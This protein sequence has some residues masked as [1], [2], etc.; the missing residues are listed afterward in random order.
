MTPCLYVK[1]Q[2]VKFDRIAPAG[3]KILAVLQ[4][5]T[6]VF[7]RDLVITCATEG[8]PAS[9]AHAL[10]EAYDVR[11]A[12]LPEATVLSLHKYLSTNL[13]PRF[14]VLYEVPAKPA[15]VLGGIA[16]VNPKATAAHFH[17]QRRKG[18]TYPPPD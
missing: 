7:D 3:F 8:H 14:T 18:T 16:Y 13:G 4:N 15:G 17:I 12:N 2:S 9:D 11:A 6:Y 1:D 10:G 5:S